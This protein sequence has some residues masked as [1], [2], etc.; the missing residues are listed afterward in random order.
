MLEAFPQRGLLLILNYHRLGNADITPFDSGVFSATADEFNSQMTYLKRRFHLATLEEALEIVRGKR[1][2]GTTV[3]I[4]FDDGYLDNYEIAFPILHAHGIQG[5]FF[6]PTA[7]IGTGKLPW[8]DIIAFIV[9][10]SLRKRI[11]LEYPERSTFDIELNGLNRTVM[12]ILQLFIQ[13]NVKEPDQFIRHLEERCE[14]SRPNG[15]VQRCFLSWQE[16]REMQEQGMAFGSHTHNHEIL[17]KLPLDSQRQEIAQS[18]TILEREL[19][20][21]IDILAYPVGLKHCF[22]TDTMCVLRQAGYRAAFSFYGG[23]NRFGRTEV[24]DIH[25][26]SVGDQSYAHF[27]LQNTLSAIVGARLL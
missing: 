8:W 6:L 20:H 25:R 19:G 2:R 23:L 18:R 16:A 22:T 10:N 17:A 26:C 11:H 24:F 1:I 14:S 27:R 9:K 3:V 4:T 5:V 12:Q 15:N 7:F 21:T 13:P